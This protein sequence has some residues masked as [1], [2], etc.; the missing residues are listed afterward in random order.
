MSVVALDIMSAENWAELELGS[1]DSD[2]ERRTEGDT[3]NEGEPWHHVSR[4]KRVLLFGG[5]LAFALVFVVGVAGTASSGALPPPNKMMNVPAETQLAVTKTGSGVG[6]PA[7]RGALATG[8]ASAYA[9]ES[10]MAPPANVSGPV[11]QTAPTPLVENK[12]R[13]PAASLKPA[14][15]MWDGNSCDDSEELYAG[16][17][18]TKCS[19]LT[20]KPQAKRLTAFSCCPTSDCHSDVSKI[21]KLQTASL[22]PCHGYDVSSADGGVACPHVQGACLEDEEQFMGECFEKCS[23]LTHG[24]YTQRV[25]AASCCNPGGTMFGCFN[26]GNDYTNANLNVGGGA[27]DGDASTPSGSHFPLKSL[28]ETK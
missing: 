4:V 24:K 15:N 3:D 13:K 8:P 10:S 26:F 22:V 17:C 11:A 21:L 9:G 19:I 5:T 16:L 20:G 25:A 14:E 7:V 23:I 6:A 1:S 18:Y 27:G 12:R 28:T 2:V